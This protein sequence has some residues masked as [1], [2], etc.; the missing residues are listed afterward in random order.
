M[1]RVIQK[2]ISYDPLRMF[3][4]VFSGFQTLSSCIFL[5]LLEFGLCSF[6][7]QNFSILY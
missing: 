1:Y 4:G 7:L 2:I 5:S 6:K 3:G